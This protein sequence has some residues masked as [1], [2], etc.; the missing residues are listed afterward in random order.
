MFLLHISGVTIVGSSSMDLE[1][2][3]FPFHVAVG[4]VYSISTTAVDIFRFIRQFEVTKSMV[5]VAPDCPK[6]DDCNRMAHFSIELGS[7][8]S[9]DPNDGNFQLK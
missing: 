7:N 8:P 1:R 3:D 9:S 5:F 6:I 4:G 2:P